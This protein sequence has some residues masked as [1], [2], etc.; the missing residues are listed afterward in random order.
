MLETTCECQ[1]ITSV[2]SSECWSESVWDSKANFPPVKLHLKVSV[3]GGPV[4]SHTMFYVLF[5]EHKVLC[6]TETRT[7]RRHGRKCIGRDCF[8]WSWGSFFSWMLRVLPPSN[9]GTHDGPA[10]AS[11]VWDYKWVCSLTCCLLLFS[12][13]PLPFLHPL[14]LCK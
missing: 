13:I 2:C 14:V 11:G 12:H 3:E 9:D 8:K 10:S 1:L 7:D 4:F 6:W 5:H